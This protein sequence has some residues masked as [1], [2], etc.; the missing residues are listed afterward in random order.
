MRPLKRRRK[1][2]APCAL[3]LKSYQLPLLRSE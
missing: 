3:T 1:L 2:S